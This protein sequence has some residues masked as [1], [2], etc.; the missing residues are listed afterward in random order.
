MCVFTCATYKI[1]NCTAA[2]FINKYH[3]R[4]VDKYEHIILPKSNTVTAAKRRKESWQKKCAT[5]NA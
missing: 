5:V 3:F 2:Y 1:A 4:I